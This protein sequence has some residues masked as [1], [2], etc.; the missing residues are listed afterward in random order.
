MS[1]V[2]KLLFCGDVVGKSGRDVLQKHLP[3]LRKEWNLDA[4]IV[5]GE[6][7][8]HGFGIN[9][10]ICKEFFALGVDA[11]TTG[12]HAFDQ[13]EVVSYISQEKR[14]IR[15]LNYPEKTPGFGMTTITTFKGFK[16]LVINLMAR[17]FMQPLD[18]PFHAIDVVLQ[19]NPMPQLYN[20]IVVDFHGEASSEKMAMGHFCD[21]R[22]SL[23]VGTHT[24]IPTSDHRI[25][26]KGSAYITDVGM[27]G[28]YD[29]VVGMEKSVP[30]HKFV[31]QTP[32]LGRMQPATGPATLCGVYVEIDSKT[33]L[34]QRIESIKIDGLLKQE[35]L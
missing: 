11:I 23:I 20:A 4:I 25:L 33:G 13:K 10:Q 26:S 31:K 1:S 7:A 16:I 17:V 29:S 35:T 12:N 5:N 19:K 30:L 14:L 27:C 18:D 32:P 34:A 15:P 6:N 9:A 22:A 21:G 24:H 3:R 28:D 2:I 8:A